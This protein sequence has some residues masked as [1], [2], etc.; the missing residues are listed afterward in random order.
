MGV[1]CKDAQVIPSSQ[2]LFEYIRFGNLRLGC[3]KIF[4]LDGFENFVSMHRNMAGR[5]NTDFYVSG[6]DIENR[7]FD[8][9]PD[10]KAFI[11]FSRKY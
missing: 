9:V 10:N 8:F 5:L 2:K 6:T 7:N 1:E 11:F 3:G 4:P